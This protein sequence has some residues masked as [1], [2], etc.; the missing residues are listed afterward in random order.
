MTREAHQW[1]QGGCVPHNNL[2]VVAAANN[3]CRF[4]PVVVQV[5]DI[6]DMVRTDLDL[7]YAQVQGTG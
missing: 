5:E 6:K 1:L 3:A 2:A 4:R 7:V